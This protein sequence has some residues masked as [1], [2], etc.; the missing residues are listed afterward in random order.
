M[1]VNYCC[2]KVFERSLQQLGDR[3]FERIAGLWGD[4]RKAGNV[5]L[6]LDFLA[7]TSLPD[8]AMSSDSAK[9]CH[10]ERRQNLTVVELT[11]WYNANA[12]ENINSYGN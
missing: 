8:V 4:G 7:D 12:T 6:L 11:S 2:C 1:R 9:V 10:S 5:R 3:D